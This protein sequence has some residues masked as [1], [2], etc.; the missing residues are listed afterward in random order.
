MLA[1]LSEAAPFF[2]LDAFNRL[3]MFCTPTSKIGETV[4]SGVD[5]PKPSEC[6]SDVTHRKS[7]EDDEVVI[8]G[9][10]NHWSSREAMVFCFATY[11]TLPRLYFTV[12]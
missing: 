4:R 7:K 3:I 5:T 10:I 2:S 11:T 12:L 8:V 9:G 1:I 6:R